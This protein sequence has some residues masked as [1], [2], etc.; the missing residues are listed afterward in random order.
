MLHFFDELPDDF[1]DDYQFLLEDEAITLP[2]FY[3]LLSD[4]EVAYSFTLVKAR[5]LRPLQRTLRLPGDLYTYVP[6]QR[7][8]TIQLIGKPSSGPSPPFQLYYPGM[9]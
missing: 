4:I 5:W 7:P 1:L 6:D 3:T 8:I 2:E 9:S